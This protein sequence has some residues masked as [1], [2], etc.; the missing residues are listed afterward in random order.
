MRLNDNGFKIKAMISG[1]NRR[2]MPYR[3]MFPVNIKFTLIELLVVIAIIAILAAMLLPALNKARD[4]ART[5]VCINNLKQLGVGFTQYFGDNDDLLPPLDTA[6]A[7]NP[8]SWTSYLTT[9][10]KISAG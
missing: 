3:H 7:N 5:A 2:S 9:R 6:S 1:L 4:K 10:R 8:P